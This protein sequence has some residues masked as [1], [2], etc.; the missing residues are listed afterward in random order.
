M[1]GKPWRMGVAVAF[2]FL[3]ATPLTAD[4]L[5]IRINC[6]GEAYVSHGGHAFIADVA[7]TSSLPIGYTESDLARNVSFPTGGSSDPKLFR[8]ARANWSYRFDDLPN[9]GYI[10][11]LLFAD[12]DSFHQEPFG[13]YSMAWLTLNKNWELGGRYDYTEH[14]DNDADHEW[15]ITPFLTYYLN[16]ALYL[17]A[18]YRYRELIG[19]HDSENMVMLQCVW[20]MGPHSHRLEE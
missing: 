1:S 9:G 19:S 6:G 4:A 17:R 7:W 13:L 10:V 8:T 12:I 5:E 3:P 18:Q 11:E 20:G 14:P 15:A 16:E 2:V